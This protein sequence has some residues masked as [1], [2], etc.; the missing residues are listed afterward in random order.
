MIAV[1][2]GEPPARVRAYVAE[3][4]LTLPVAIDATGT[5]GRAYGVQFTPMHFLIDRSGVVR[6]GGAGA[7]DWTGPAA[8]AAARLLLASPVPHDRGSMPPPG[9]TERR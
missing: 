2:L 8:R 1:N 9:R 4:G 5:V 7:R 3:L 6:A